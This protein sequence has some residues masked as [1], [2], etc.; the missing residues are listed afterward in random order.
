[1]HQGG[2]DVTQK[3]TAINLKSFVIDVFDFV[4][5]EGVTRWGTMIGAVHPK[6][7]SKGLSLT[8]ALTR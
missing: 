5:V 3:L 6:K 2:L 1:M 8:H 7:Q 4:V